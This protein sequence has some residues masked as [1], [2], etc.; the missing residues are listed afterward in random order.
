[1][2]YPTAWR[3]GGCGLSERKEPKTI[4]E[5]LAR[6]ESSRFAGLTVCFTGDLRPYCKGMTRDYAVYCL[7]NMGGRFWQKKGKKFGDFIVVV[8]ANRTIVDGKCKGIP[9]ITAAEFL[10]LIDQ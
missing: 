3:C 4:K 1:M 5:I 10:Q 9:A 8:G 7:E 2:H 6:P